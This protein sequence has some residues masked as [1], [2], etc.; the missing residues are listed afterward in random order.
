MAGIFN[1]RKA[2]KFKT[3]AYLNWLGGPSSEI[4][5][6]LLRLRLAA[7]M[8]LF[9][10]PDYYPRNPAAPVVASQDDPRWLLTDR[11]VSYLRDV[12]GAVDPPDWRYLTPAQLMERAIDDA[13]DASVEA[14]L[15]EAIRLRQEADIRVT[16]GVIL[17]RA[18]NHPEGRGSGL[19][20]QL[21]P[22]IV[23]RAD[24]P[25]IGLAYQLARY[26]KPVP[27]ALKKAWQEALEGFDNLE[28]A[29]HRLEGG[30]PV[31]TLDVVNLV[32]AQ[33]APINQLM[34]GQLRATGLTWEAIVS[35][36]GSNRAAWLDALNVMDHVALVRNLRNLVEAGVEAERFADALVDGAAAEGVVPFRYYAAYNAVRKARAPRG[37]SGDVP[38]VLEA[39]E[40]A[41][42]AAL[43]RQPRF[44]GRVMVL[45]DNSGS[46]RGKTRSSVGR[47]RVATIGNLTAIVTTLQADIGVVGIFGDRLRTFRVRKGSSPLDLLNRAE[48]IGRRIGGRTEY[49]LWLFWDD[50]IQKKQ[51][52]DA[53]FVLSDMQAGHGALYG[54]RAKDYPQYVWAKAGG[55]AYLDV[56]GLVAAYREQVNAGVMVYLVQTNGY[57]ET[58][59]P[60]FYERTYILGGWGEGLL[61]FAAEMQALYRVPLTN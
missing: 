27:N 10:E 43:G 25:A 47:L 35:Q 59:V 26:G 5:D 17:A 38:V 23:T 57:A 4:S 6:P 8:C 3:L 13:L 16:P 2:P 55:N 21:A 22:W 45:V 15:H 32:H 40:E 29:R 11:A 37:R 50:A 30:H 44:E 49:G 28:L 9:G 52:W 20:R 24:D 48:R 1:R 12:L 14:T 41:M 39:I 36:R 46:A 58:I 53:I 18:A 31:K 19:I 42:Q 61:R 51:R 56:P 33:S 7:L 54:Q 60:E 34:R